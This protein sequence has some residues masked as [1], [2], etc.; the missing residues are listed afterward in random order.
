MNEGIKITLPEFF[1]EE[2]VFVFH[3]IAAPYMIKVGEALKDFYGMVCSQGAS[4]C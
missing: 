4:F 2:R 1:A 3:A